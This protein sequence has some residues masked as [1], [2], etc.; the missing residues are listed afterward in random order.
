M[1]MTTTGDDRWRAHFS[2]RQSRLLRATIAL[3]GLA[4]ALAVVSCTR[5]TGPARE[6]APAQRGRA[7]TRPN[8]LLIVA[9]D[10]A[11]TLG[12]YGHPVVSSPGIDRLAGEGVLFERAYCQYPL[13][14]PSRTSL[15]SGRRP[16]TTHVVDNQ[17]RPRSTLGRNVDFLPG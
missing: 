10:L 17:T 6:E 1:T 5:S 9:D 13:C 2:K 11:A 3:C 12:A 4:T 16:E 8:V 7:P 15:L 14:N